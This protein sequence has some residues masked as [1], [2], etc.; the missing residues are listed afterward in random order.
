LTYSQWLA[1]LRALTDTRDA[2]RLWR[3][4]R[5][6][7]AY[8]LGEELAGPRGDQS[9]VQGSVVYGIWLSWGLLY[10][11]QTTEASRRL[12]DL[13]VGESH[14]LANTFPPETWDRIVIV[15]WPSLPQAQAVLQDVDRNLVGLAL[16]HRLQLRLK[17]LVN[18]YRRTSDG[19]WRSIDWSTSK[20]RGARAATNLGELGQQVDELWDVASAHEAGDAEL[21]PSVRCIRPGNLLRSIGSY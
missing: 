9:V 10:V 12:R 19:G 16:E 6:E 1:G 18:A 5:F 20:S 15:N 2:A 3:E 21:P 13:P 7:F 14:H 11:G 4:R 8:R 17:P